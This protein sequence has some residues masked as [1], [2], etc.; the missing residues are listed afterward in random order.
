M[1]GREVAIITYLGSVLCP[2]VRLL[3]VSWLLISLV[4]R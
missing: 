4:Y 2:S 3:Y 1:F